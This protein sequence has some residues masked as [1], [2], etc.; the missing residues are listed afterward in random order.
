MDEEPFLKA[1]TEAKRELDAVRVQI[2][3]LSQL[4]L[5]AKVLEQF[6]E[7]AAAVV[8]EPE[9]TNELQSVD[10]VL[11]ENRA[12]VLALMRFKRTTSGRVFS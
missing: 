12:Q 1:I 10:M 2:Q 11:R 3:Q 7:S 8:A 4:H 9:T 5:R 6:L